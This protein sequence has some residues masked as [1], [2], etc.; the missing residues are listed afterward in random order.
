MA[1]P[2]RS[3]GSPQGTLAASNAG[4]LSRGNHTEITTEAC[5]S[6]FR[7]LARDNAK[8]GAPSMRT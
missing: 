6:V 7:D 8:V 4:M 1:S 5:G 3:P 2:L